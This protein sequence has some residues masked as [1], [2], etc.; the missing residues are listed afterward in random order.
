MCALIPGDRLPKEVVKTEIDFLKTLGAI[1]IKYNTEIKNPENLKKKY[2]SVILTSGLKDQIKLNIPN[3]DLGIEGLNY[4]ANQGKYNV[5]GKNVAVIGGGAVAV[6][7][8]MTAARRGAAKVEICTR[9]NI[10]AIQLP[11]KELTDL[12]KAGIDINGR[13][14]ITEILSAKGKI[15]ALKAAKEMAAFWTSKK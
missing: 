12:I 9:K 6:D 8:A 13:T 1:T 15:K 4:L 14:R 7:C 3:E 5:K 2:A 10:G 11:E